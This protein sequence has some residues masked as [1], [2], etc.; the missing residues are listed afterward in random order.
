M[1][2]ASLGVVYFCLAFSQRLAAAQNLGN[3][4][5]TRAWPD[6]PSARR[7]AQVIELVN[8]GDVDRIG[9][10]I[11]EVYAQPFRDAAKIEEHVGVFTGVRQQAGSLEFFSV[12]K[13]DQE[14]PANEIVIIMKAG[15]TDTWLGM[16][17]EVEP[18]PPNRILKL[19]FAPARPPIEAAEL[20]P[21]ITESQMVDE[22]R[23]YCEKL[24][25]ADVFSGAVLFARNGKPLFRHAY[26]IADRNFNVPNRVETRFNI[27]SMNK[28]F[29]AIAI[30]QLAE[31]GRLSFSDPVGKFL[32][33]DWLDPVLAS[34]IT[35]DQCLTHTSGLGNYFNEQF[36]LASRDRFREISDYK[37]LI[38]TERA[39]FDPG[40]EWS[41]SNTGYLLL[42]A[43]IEKVAGV[44]YFDYIREN[45]YKPAGMAETDCFDLDRPTP[46]LAVGYTRVGDRLETNTF[47]HVI[48]GGP[49]GGGYSTIDD[50]LRFDAALRNGTLINADSASLLWTVT[51]QSASR[52]SCGRGFFV[53]G[54]KGNARVIG[55]TGGFPGISA[56]FE[57]HVDAGFTVIVLSNCD[58]AALTVAQKINELI[59][60]CVK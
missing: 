39:A 20:I 23:R 44:S 31:R 13:Y 24:A 27:G 42:G 32:E 33:P 28:M 48:R 56:V 59:A 19:Q 53:R 40:A 15:L 5:D 43:V 38:S 6:V 37:L 2:P 4:S 18:E 12:R 49:A 21:R 46:N 30:A 47:K 36:T 41:Y 57:M 60:R 58:Q 25:G 35:I 7:A 55:H 54:E 51:P 52:Q 14:R 26:G 3:Y 11:A 17:L 22:L 34:K 9:A 29:T 8:S 1:R 50:L 16:I 10:Y 45:V